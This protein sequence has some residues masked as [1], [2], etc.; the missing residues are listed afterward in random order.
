MILDQSG[1]TPPASRAGILPAS[2][3]FQEK[4]PENRQVIDSGVP[5][6]DGRK[7]EE[8]IA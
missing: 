8:V 5:G 2:P 1:L 6:R 7:N 4:V 3:G